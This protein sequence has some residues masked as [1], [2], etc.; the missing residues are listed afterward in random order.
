MFIIANLIQAAAMVINYALNIYMYIIIIQ[1]ILSWV[2][3]DPYN[4]IVRF[5]H[6]VTEPILSRIRALIPTTYSSIDFSPLIV[7]LVINFLQN[8]L[9]LSMQNVAAKLVM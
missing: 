2:N 8:F 3:V 7:I 5:I 9:V 4:P 6:D 1:V